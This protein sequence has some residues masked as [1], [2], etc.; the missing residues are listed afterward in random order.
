[1]AKPVEIDY[2]LKDGV[3]P[4][5][6][7][8]EGSAASTEKTI[9]RTAESIKTRLREQ[10]ETVRV[11]ESDLRSLEKQL[12]DA[13][14]GNA[15]L[16]MKA[17]V[18][19]CKKVLAEE[20]VTLADIEQQN[21]KTAVSGK[22]L[23]R[24]LRV[25]V[26][27]MTRM[28]LEG[29]QLTP[30]YVEMERRAAELSDTLGDVR[31][32]TNVLAHDNAGLQGVISGVSGLTG[33]VTAGVG[34]MGIFTKNNEDLVKVQTKVQSVLAVTMGLQQMMNVLNKDS[35]FRLVTLRKVKDAFTAANT[36]LAVSLGISNVAAKALMA[37]LTLGLSAAIGVAIALW[38]RYRSKQ[39]AAKEE[40]EAFS[41]K[42]AESAAKPISAINELSAAWSKLGNDM[43]AKKKF[44]E[45]NKKRFD[46]LGI[47]VGSVTDA[48]NLLVANKSKFIEACLARAKALAVQ[49]LAVE[50]YKEVLLAQQELEA[51]PKGYVTKRGTYT[52]GYGTQRKG[53]VLVKDSKWQGAEDAVTEAQRG[54]DMLIEQ[55]VEF[56]GKER[57]ILASIGAGADGVI[58]GSVAAIEKV[59]AS[60]RELLKSVTNKEEYDRIEKEIEVEEKRLARITGGSS[61][62][63]DGQNGGGNNDVAKLQKQLADQAAQARID[64]MDDGLAKTL[65]QNRL[66]HDRELAQ[67]EQLG[68]ELLAAHQKVNK[69]ITELP[70]SHAE[71]IGAM[72]SSADANYANADKEARDAVL[73]DMMTFQQRYV[74]IIEDSNKKIRDAQVAGASLD[75]FGELSEQEREQIDQLAEEFAQKSTDY[76][77]FM[78]SMVDASIEEIQAQIEGANAII[79]QIIQGGIDDDE[80]EKYLEYRARLVAMQKELQEAKNNKGNT[81][82]SKEADKSEDSWQKLYATLQKVGKEFD[83]IGEAVGGVAGDVIK[84][85]GNIATSTLSII[86]GIVSFSEIS[87]QTIAGVSASAASAIKAVEKASV[88]LAIIGAVMQV[89]Q[90]VTGLFKDN[91]EQLR[92]STDAV[93]EYQRALAQIKVSKQYDLFDTIFGVDALGKFEAAVEIAGASLEQ[94]GD[95]V[96]A[97]G[98]RNSDAYK[99]LLKNGSLKDILKNI[100]KANGIEATFDG[101]SKWNK[102]WGTGNGKIKNHL[103]DIN[104]YINTDGSLKLEEMQ[105]WFDK[106]NAGLD[107]EEKKVIQNMLDAGGAYDEAMQAQKE[108]L[109]DMFG[110]LAS[111]IAGTV[112]DTFVEKGREGLGDLEDIVDDVSK[113]MAKSIVSKLIFDKV[114]TGLSDD[115]WSFV[116]GGDYAGAADIIRG[117]VDGIKTMVPELVNEMESLGLVAGEISDEAQGTTQSGRAGA[118]TT[119]SQDQ[120]AKLEGLGTANQ[121]ILRDISVDVDEIGLGLSEATGVLVEIRDYVREVKES[122]AAILEKIIEVVR[123]GI[124]VK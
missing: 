78:R 81:D 91:E 63:S 67:I 113:N 60:K 69:N 116:Q 19:A 5:L 8:I 121:M 45:E 37:T 94:I 22:R 79:S 32:Q 106:F 27:T 93:Y 21:D 84:T 102:L 104:E 3:S 110:D 16:E 54:Y 49:E 15:W 12:D 33:A 61:S 117:A 64:A 114:L 100:D 36:R 7:K 58:E 59:I 39:A 74:K 23:S 85:A 119:I 103:F 118:L 111:N 96:G 120:G 38:E 77:E 122:S 108:Y 107:E 97:I 92:A 65:A 66:N 99:N 101:R 50:K 72:V 95:Q 30:E 26:D 87:T 89:I 71:M 88:I 34:V 40:A 43:D 62:S 83:E 9:A 42:V 82:S 57:E 98:G 53:K 68:R 18:E 90:T 124:K 46:E 24:E 73:A 4:G 115:V 10:R 47:S 44:V 13:T 52:D 51:T 48:E 56:S 41:K 76:E 123:D 70:A 20:K 25:L 17:E 2:L 105:A 1:M 14:P 31:A 86:S 75:M 35:A 109:Q 29:K 11:V 112:V 6:N 80:I 55:Q 28:R